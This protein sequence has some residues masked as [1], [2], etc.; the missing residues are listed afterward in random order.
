MS[1]VLQRRAQLLAKKRRRE[2]RVRSVGAP[3]RAVL[4]VVELPAGRR[5]E[6]ATEF[7][8]GIQHLHQLRPPVYSTVVRKV[9][10]KR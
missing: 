9:E 7:K 6:G 10:C 3:C 4:V 2:V 5:A 1:E 8:V